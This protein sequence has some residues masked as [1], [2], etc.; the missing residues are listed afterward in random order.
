M[1]TG[2]NWKRTRLSLKM[3]NA[4]IRWSILLGLFV[5]VSN[6]RAGGVPTDCTQLIVAVGPNWDS[7][8]GQM[9]FFERASPNAQWTRTGSSF[10]VLFG[11]K[12]AAWGSG[13]AGQN[14]T[15]LHKKERDGRAPA[16]VFRI[17]TIYTYD[18]HLPSGA[19]YP[20]HQVGLADA[21]VDD[22]TSPDYNRFIT[23]DDPAKPPPWFE[24][25][26]MRHNDFAYRWLVEIR[27][28]SDPPVPGEGSAIFFHIR[29]GVSRPTTGCTTMA[30]PNLVNLIRWLRA[31]RHPCYALLPRNEYESR[32]QSW[33][34]P[35]PGELPPP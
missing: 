17:G 24:K 18:P 10:P 26:K 35:N 2:Q 1:V 33:N 28:N 13:L 27:H 16:G 23:I 20:F 21:W 31:P 15:G 14:E 8:H 5:L 25:Q 6:A 11:K 32:W 30:E 34:L 3:A 29:R 22:V 19:D 12:G 4:T 7:M 9:Q